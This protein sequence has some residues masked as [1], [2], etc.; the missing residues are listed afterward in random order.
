MKP[1]MRPSSGRTEL[2][3]RVSHLTVVFRRYNRS[4]DLNADTRRELSNQ[5][6]DANASIDRRDD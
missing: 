3:Q 4:V 5:L 2:L 6:S 1:K